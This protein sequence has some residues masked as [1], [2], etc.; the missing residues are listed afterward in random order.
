MIA[1][2]SLRLLYLIFQHAL[3][4]VLLMGRASSTK[5]IELHA[6]GA[7]PLCL[8]P[9]PPST[10]NARRTQRWALSSQPYSE[11][12]CASRSTDLNPNGEAVHRDTADTLRARGKHTVA[13]RRRRRQ[14]NL[15]A[16]ARVL[17]RRHSVAASSTTTK[18]T[19]AWPEL[20]IDVRFIAASP[21][22]E[23]RHR[24]AN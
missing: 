3:G 15:R 4:L 1:A 24:V 23:D 9:H 5:D 19:R 20:G 7:D 11:G 21:D 22:L 10:S 16:V 17:E 18:S 13:P 8:R 2:V 12:L 14:A 6:R